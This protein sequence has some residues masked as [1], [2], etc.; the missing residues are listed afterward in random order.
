MIVHF[1]I[2]KSVM[3][4]LNH[5]SVG[6]PIYVSHALKIVKNRLKMKETDKNINGQINGLLDL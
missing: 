1:K 2:K 6:K 4:A 3:N 5:V